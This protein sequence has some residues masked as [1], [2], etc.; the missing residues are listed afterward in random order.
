MSPVGHTLTGLAIGAAAIPMDWSRRR[1]QVAF[2][3]LALLANAPDLPLPDWGHE[4]YDIS[5]SIFTTLVGCLIVALLATWLLKLQKLFAWS[6]L[7]AGVE[8]WYSHLLLDTFYNHGKGLAVYWPLS[9]GRIA[10]PIPWFRTLS[11]DQ[12]FCWRN[13][14]VAAIEA[15]CYGMVLA[16]AWVLYRKKSRSQAAS[17]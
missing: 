17:P 15:V 4:R 12:V 11:A 8:A 1:K 3:C 10:L 13:F 6:L 16:A 7:L 2:G 14:R 9:D 5:H